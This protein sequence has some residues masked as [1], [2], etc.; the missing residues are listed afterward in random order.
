MSRA[1]RLP[2]RLRS[3]AVHGVGRDSW[4]LPRRVRS[5]SG[6]ATAQ[7][8]AVATPRAV[9]GRLAHVSVL[10]SMRAGAWAGLVLGLVLGAPLGAFVAWLAGAIVGWQRDL[11]LTLGIARNLLPFG[12][13]IGVLRTISTDWLVVVPAI[14]LGSAVVGAVILSLVGGILAAA[15]NATGGHASIV[16]D[17]EP[18]EG[19]RPSDAVG[20]ETEAD[21]E[22]WRA[23]VGDDAADEAP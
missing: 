20:I 11:S 12:D 15:Y 5:R 6:Q 21:A 1:L 9:R 3:A 18:A 23:P 16:V 13:Q 19:R 7:A 8:A 10:A 4:P 22:G 2:R 17:L 14:A